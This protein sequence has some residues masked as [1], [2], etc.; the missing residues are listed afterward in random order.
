MSYPYPKNA[1][2]ASL[3]TRVTSILPASQSRKGRWLK[4]EP[5][6]RLSLSGELSGGDGGLGADIQLNRRLGEGSEAYIGYALLADR[7]DTG[8]EAQNLF[9]SSN[10][11]TLTV[12][13]RQRFS[14]SLSIYSENRI[15]HGGTA[16]S[17]TRSFGMTFDPS[18]IW[19][20]SGSFENG[21]IDDVNTGLFKRTA[22]TIG[23]G[24]STETLRVSSNV[25]ARFETGNGGDRQV[26]LFRNTIN[27]KLNR[28]WRFLERFNF[29]LADNDAANV[30]AAD[31]V[32]AQAGFAYRPV[33]NDRLNIGAL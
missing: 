3:P 23:A 8:L 22:A 5:T 33:D 24:Y 17:L 13:A 1:F 14:T 4:A 26:W 2:R 6:E 19:S 31:F 29:A 18:A 32:E 27:A 28:D 11:G 25:E 21:R 30:R 9:N 20:F 7:S 10:R 15:E 16:P 12:G